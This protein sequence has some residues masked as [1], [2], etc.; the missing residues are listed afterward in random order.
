MTYLGER[1]D[2]DRILEGLRKMAE[3]LPDYAWY[4]VLVAERDTSP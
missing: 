3:E 1:Y 4:L 2:V